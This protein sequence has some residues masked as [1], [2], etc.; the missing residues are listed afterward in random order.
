MSLVRPVTVDASGFPDINAAGGSLV[1]DLQNAGY[2]IASTASGPAITSIPSLSV[3]PFESG[4]KL[5]T[6]LKANAGVAVFI[7]KQ[8]F[9]SADAE[10]INYAGMRLTSTDEN[11]D[12]GLRSGFYTDLVKSTYRN[13]V[14]VKLGGE[15]RFGPVTARA[16]FAYYQDP[17][18]RTPQFSNLDRSRK[19]FSGGL[20][21][22]T[23]RF[24]LDGAVQYGRQQTAYAP[25]ILS[26][27]QDY[28]SGLTKSNQL[29]GTCLL[30]TS[31]SPRD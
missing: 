13:T 20:G 30:Y 3:L 31:P 16:G 28:A 19:I 14:N 27:S 18:Q 10:L 5:R 12:G 21:Y 7:G 15:Y 4:Y 26:N 1:T 6:P 29:M 17:F 8:G 25:Y 11:A 23:D 9:L 24:F 22:R 2:G